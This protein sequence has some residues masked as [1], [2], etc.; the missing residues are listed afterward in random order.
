MKI[1][2]T[3]SK[4][5]IGKNLIAELRNRGYTEILEYTRGMD[6]G[7]LKRLTKECEFI[8]HLAGANRPADPNEFT[9]TNVGL[10]RDLIELLIRNNNIVPVV[11]ASSIQAGN[12]TAYGKSKKEAEELWLEYAEQYGGKVYIFRLPNVFGKWSRP[13]YNSVVATFCHNIA[14][15]LDIEIFDE[16]AE[17]TLCYIDD[18]VTEF[19]GV[20]QGSVSKPMDH[21]YCEIP[22]SYK[23]TVKQL[24]E[25]IKSFNQNRVTLMMPSLKN[26]LDKA[27]YAT[28][29]SYL[30]EG[31]F[32]YTLPMREDERGWLAEFIKSEYNGQIFISKTKPGVTRGN[33]WHHSKV[34]KFLVLQGEALIKF[35]KYGTDDVISYQVSGERLEV[36][37]IPAGYVH[38]ITNMGTGDLITLFWANEIF[39]PDR[40]DTYRME[41]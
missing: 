17:L 21:G 28:Y 3:G 11:I 40:T 20:L 9:R 24:A 31:D 15:G 30:D 12:D 27:L 26:P 29:L 7:V 37:D 22:T 1:L 4:G 2:I 23:L 32:S 33:H 34:E 16:E 10:A 25:K 35:R 14:R 5:F 39:D 13:N 41:V 6:L 19:V 8:F 38:S 18:V 36:V